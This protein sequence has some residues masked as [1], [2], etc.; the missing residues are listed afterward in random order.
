MYGGLHRGRVDVA[1]LEVGRT[2]WTTPLDAV[3]LEPGARVAAG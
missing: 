2:S 1:A 3:R